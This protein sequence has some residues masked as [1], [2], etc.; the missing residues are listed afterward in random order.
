[1]KKLIY[2]FI[3]VSVGIIYYTFE[4]FLPKGQAIV[5]SD[6][7]LLE[8]PFLSLTDQSILMAISWLSSILLIR[9][10]NL[11][12]SKKLISE[13]LLLPTLGW[14][15][16]LPITFCMALKGSDYFLVLK[17]GFGFNTIDAIVTYIIFTGTE[18]NEKFQQY[19]HSRA[20]FWI[21]TI[22]GLPIILLPPLLMAG[23]NL[24]IISCLITFIIAC[25]LLV[26]SIIEKNHKAQKVQ[27]IEI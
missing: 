1:M 21:V 24:A 3:A 18:E 4:E 7:K 22:T 5:W 16:I 10:I 2:F 26:L 15:F 12:I 19:E 13:F 23:I 20:S 27:E 9:K 8:L 14:M 11:S 25:W 6:N 17:A